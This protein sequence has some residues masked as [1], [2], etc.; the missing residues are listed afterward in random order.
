MVSNVVAFPLVQQ[1]RPHRWRDS[2]PCSK[3]VRV[4]PLR[5]G[6]QPNITRKIIYLRIVQAAISRTAFRKMNARLSIM[7]PT[8]FEPA[9]LGF[10]SS[11]REAF[12]RSDLLTGVKRPILFPASLAL[13]RPARAGAL[14]ACQVLNHFVVRTCCQSF[15]L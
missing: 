15:Q 10:P 6:R 11:P 5:F 12:S 7:G 2:L 9:T 8:G 1:Y 3:W 13:P 4:Y 14:R